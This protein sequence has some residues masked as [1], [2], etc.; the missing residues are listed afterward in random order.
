MNVKKGKILIGTSGWHYKHWLGP[1]YPEKTKS[2]DFMAYYQQ[3]FQTVEIN[4]SFYRLPSA[5]T[6]EQWK[7]TTPEDFIFSV[8]ANRYITHIKKL[9]ES[10]EFFN[11][12]MQHA[13]FLQ[14]KLGPILFQLPPKW[15]YNEDRFKAF[16]RIL[17]TNYRYT[18]EF[19]DPTWHNSAALDLLKQHNIALCFYEL[20]FYTSPIDVTANFI[21]VRLHGPGEKYQGSYNDETLLEW[22]NKCKKWQEKGL[23]V[24]VYFDNDQKGYAANNAKKLKAL[25]TP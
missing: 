19:R 6:F 7:E 20:G 3:Y 11:T 9:S 16:L 17:P 21:Y 13:D 4:N 15:H 12:F 25:T 10:E 14:E 2:P 18:F 5:K 8:K 24:F 22:A 1:F 23:D